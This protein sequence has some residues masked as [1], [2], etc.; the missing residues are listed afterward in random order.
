M[1]VFGQKWLYSGGVVLFGQS[2]CI[3]AK[4]VVFV[5]KFVFGQN[6][7]YSGKVVVFGQTLLY[8]V[9]TV[10]IGENWF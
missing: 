2:G 7:L 6:W 8:L 4:V 9:N 1:V 3:R 5:N 10:V